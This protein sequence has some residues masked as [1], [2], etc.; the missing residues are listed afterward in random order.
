MTIDISNCG[1]LKFVSVESLA[2]TPDSDVSFID[3]QIYDTRPGFPMKKVS[4]GLLNVNFN[5]NENT[6]DYYYFVDHTV[7]SVLSF[8]F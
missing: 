2:A 5:P 4:H 8:L 3:L 1:I 7:F 6:T